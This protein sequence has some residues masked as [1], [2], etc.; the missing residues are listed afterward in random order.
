MFVRFAQ[1]TVA[2]LAL[3]GGSQVHAVPLVYGTYY[4]EVATTCALVNPST[5]RISF[6]QLPADKLLLVTK[7]SC[8]FTTSLPAARIGLFVSA[9]A[10]GAAMSRYVY[11]A[12]P[13][14]V[15]NAGVFYTNISEDPHF[16]IG[17]G[18]FP[19]VIMENSGAGSY[20]LAACTISGNLV[21]PI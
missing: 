21:A 19:F 1:I 16:L 15:G 2:S 10:G 20:A 9:T 6:S 4:D 8:T 12:I 3:V 13:P 7:V 17:Q 11:L 14:N 5:C 18:R